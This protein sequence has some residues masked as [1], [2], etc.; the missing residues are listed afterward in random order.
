VGLVLGA[1]LCGA[2]SGC[3][4]RPTPL[5]GCAKDVDCKGSRV[6]ERGACVDPVGAR[7]AASL[8]G[9]LPAPVASQHGIAA[10]QS[11]GGAP[12]PRVAITL[13]GASAML[14]GGWRH[15]GRSRYTVSGTTPR[16]Q[17][18]LE[19]GGVVISS[20]ALTDDGP[21]IF[22]AHDRNI[23]AAAVSPGESGKP[24]SLALRWTRPTGDMVWC[25]PALGPRTFASGPSGATMG[26]AGAGTDGGAASPHDGGAPA[27]AGV[28]VYVGSDDDHLYA[29]DPDTGAVRWSF[30]AGPCKRAIGFGPE[31]ARCDV[32]AVSIGPDGTIYAVAD[33][34]YA[35]DAEG[36]LLW[37]FPLRT[38]C[39]AAPAVADDGTV[40]L[41]CQDGRLYAVAPGGTKRWDLR[42]GDDIDSAPAIGADGTIYFGSDD[43]K[44]YAVRPDGTVKFALK[45]GGDVRSSPA[46]AEDG[47][48]YVGSFDANL[49]AV[50]PDGTVAFTFSAADRILSSPVIDAAG[51]I[52]FGSEDDRLYALAPD[53]KLRWSILLDGDVDGTPAIGPDGTIYVGADDKSLHALR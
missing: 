14:H 3:W 35:L 28:N 33:G 19:V 37:R 30:L 47:T 40:Y 42:T 25:A 16:W 41:G 17:S 32:D 45:T 49:Y 5:T 38:H 53:G 20:P 12:A 50:R 27:P 51:T 39:A 8:V 4:P 26:L 29:L 7:T 18:R 1:W 11:D 44:L 22:G 52:V 13:P 2:Q 36:H 24:P 43:H 31:A 21:V 9:D 10:L 23:R 48:I 46:I 15:T 34:L 6:C